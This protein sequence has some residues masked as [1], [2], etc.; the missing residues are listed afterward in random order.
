V[1]SNTYSEAYPQQGTGAYGYNNA[2]QPQQ[3][4]NMF[5]P[6]STPPNTQVFVIQEI[7]FLASHVCEQP[8]MAVVFEKLLSG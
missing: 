1:P 4:A 8:Y 6:P 5:V 7:F 3:P 2:Y